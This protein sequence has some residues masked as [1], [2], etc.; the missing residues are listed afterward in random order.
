[1]VDQLRSPQ[2]VSSGGIF[3]NVL[4][5]PIVASRAPATTDINYNIGQQWIYGTS[6]YYLTSVTAGSATW[7]ANAI[8]ASLS[9]AGA[10]VAGTTLTATTSLSVGTTSTLGGAVTIS[11]GTLTVSSGDVNIAAVSK[12]LKVKAGANCYASTATLVAGTVTVGNTIVT[13]TSKIFVMRTAVNAST[14]VGEFMVV[15]GA[16]TFTITSV[17]PSTALTETGDA[18]SVYWYVVNVT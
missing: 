7:T 3:G 15:A 14:A 10:I 13:A 4:P 2:Y 6:L 1:M 11:S 9:L 5:M 12:G 16:G 8:G 17:T 18:S